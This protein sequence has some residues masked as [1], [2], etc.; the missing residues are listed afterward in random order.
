MVPGMWLTRVE[1]SAVGLLRVREYVRGVCG[2]GE[3]ELQILSRG[4]LHYSVSFRAEMRWCEDAN[5][6]S[7]EGAD[8]VWVRLNP[9]TFPVHPGQRCVCHFW[10]NAFADN[11]T[12]LA[13]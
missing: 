6:G 12:M 2:G 11:S 13:P 9:P 10:S 3:Q 1:T 7:N 8:N 5:E 4:V